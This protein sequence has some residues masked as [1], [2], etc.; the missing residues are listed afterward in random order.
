MEV[1]QQRLVQRPNCGGGVN[2]VA[3]AQSSGVVGTG[4]GGEPGTH[5]FRVAEARRRR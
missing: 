3:M 2:G 5:A 1:A 4:S